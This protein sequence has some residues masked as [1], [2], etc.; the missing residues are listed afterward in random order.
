[1]RFDENGVGGFFE[2][3]PVLVFVIAGVSLLIVSGLRVSS[4]RGDLEEES[5]L[6]YAAEVF[7]RMIVADA[8]E[9]GFVRPTAE[10]FNET[11]IASL[12]NQTIGGLS[13]SVSIVMRYPETEWI[14]ACESAHGAQ[15]P[16]RVASD[17]KFLNAIDGNGR[18]VIIEVTAVV[19]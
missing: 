17:S 6:Q 11:R 8:G 15:T 10:S 14:L 12:A 1:M 19:W 5:S 16:L 13:Y 7:V 3:L 2:D 18:S 9:S 4:L